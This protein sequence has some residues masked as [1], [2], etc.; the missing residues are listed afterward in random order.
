MQSA[1]FV[2]REIGVGERM[3]PSEFEEYLQ[4]QF[5]S[6]GYEIFAQHVES[7]YEDKNFKGYRVFVTLVKNEEAKSAKK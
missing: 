4:Y 5:F 2:M 1:K 7:I 3:N 6:S